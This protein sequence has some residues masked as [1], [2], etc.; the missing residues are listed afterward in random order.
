MLKGRIIALIAAA[1]LI[2]AATQATAY[3]ISVNG[4]IVEPAISD[5]VVLTNTFQLFGAESFQGW[6]WSI[7]CNGCTISD[8]SFN[9]AFPNTMMWNG[10][11]IGAP[12]KDPP[13]G[14]EPGDPVPATTISSIGGFTI[15]T[16]IDAQAEFTV[17][18]VTIHITAPSGSIS[19]FLSPGEGFSV[20]GVV[21]PNFTL[22]EVVW[23][24][25]PGVALLNGVALAAI[26]LIYR[27]RQRNT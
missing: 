3:N 11:A 20:G 27:R 18:W 15:G 1:A 13:I 5:V 8:Y 12:V 22:N 25:E 14:L 10:Q 16:P 19:T 7:D 17:G 9:Y 21:D 6:D 2:S 26:G 24:P 4:T 23:T